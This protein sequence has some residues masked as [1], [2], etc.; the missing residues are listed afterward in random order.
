MLI[1]EAVQGF[2]GERFLPFFLGITY[3]GGEAVYIVLL[4]L[5]YWLINPRWGP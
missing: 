2:F 3:L 1:I 4:S 5:Y